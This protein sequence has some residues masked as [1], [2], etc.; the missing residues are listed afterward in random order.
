MPHPCQRRS[1]IGGTWPALR[2]ARDRSNSRYAQDCRPTDVQVLRRQYQ[3][4]IDSAG[5]LSGE[6]RVLV[7]D[8]LLAAHE[9]GSTAVTL[10]QAIGATERQMS[11]WLRAARIRAGHRRRAIV[12]VKVV[13]E[14]HASADAPETVQHT[15]TLTGPQGLRIECSTTGTRFAIAFLLPKCRM[16]RLR[17]ANNRSQALFRS[18]VRPILWWRALHDTI[19]AMPTSVIRRSLHSFSACRPEET[20]NDS[21]DHRICK[22]PSPKNPNVAQLT[23]IGS[24]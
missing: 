12:P 18:F 14:A 23:E 2:L 19:V 24:F 3:Q 7:L 11:D 4:S 21:R 6:N 15:W 8:A 10:A 17:S 22:G 13:P 20:A 1:G 5:R 9:E 16:N